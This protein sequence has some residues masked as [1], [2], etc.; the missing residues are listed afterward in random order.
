MHLQR[1]MMLKYLGVSLSQIS[2]IQKEYQD[3][4]SGRFLYEKVQGCLSAEKVDFFICMK[5]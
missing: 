2:D 1:I 4:D 3:V 5:N